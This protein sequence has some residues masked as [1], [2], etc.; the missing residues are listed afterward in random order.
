[1][2]GSERVERRKCLGFERLI[3]GP[4]VARHHC[5]QQLAEG[6][7]AVSTFLALGPMPHPLRA[8]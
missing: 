7:M 1:V 5:P 3:L 6:A 8:V 2:D 4:E